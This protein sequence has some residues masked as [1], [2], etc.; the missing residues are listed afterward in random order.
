VLTWTASGAVQRPT[1]LQIRV[2][3]AYPGRIRA[4]APVPTR[5]M[6]PGE[7]IANLDHFTRAMRGPR[8]TPC[9]TVVLSGVGVASRADV[10]ELI[11]RARGAGVDRV[12]LHAGT[13]DLERFEPERF[14]G[15]VDRIV[16]PVQPG[17]GGGVLQQGR[18]VIRA[19][20]EQGL[21][22]TAST[23]LSALAIPQLPAVGRVLAAAEPESVVFTYP[24]PIAGNTASEV[25]GVRATVQALGRVVPA[26]ERAGVRVDL[27]GL[28]ACY[29]G[30]LASRLR[31]T[32]NRFYVDADHQCDDALR[33]FP[34]V[35]AFTKTEDCRFCAADS[36]CDGFFAT[37]LRRSGFPALAPLS[38]D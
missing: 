38:Q 2:Q 25:P 24:F 7:L 15:R 34:D 12:I 33:F 30:D 32:S 37:Y 26:L 36:R 6:T 5:S 1:T 8:T 17:P 13:E 16:V 4:G 23:Q 9:T 31:R 20:H 29:L 11:D 28:P 10:P 18:R 14:A 22:V 27:K 35:V 19:C 3:R 21:A